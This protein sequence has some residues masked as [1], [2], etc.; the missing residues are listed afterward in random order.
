MFPWRPGRIGMKDD[1]HDGERSE[2]AQHRTLPQFLIVLD[3][4][5]RHYLHQIMV[6]IIQKFSILHSFYDHVIKKFSITVQQLNPL[7]SYSYLRFSNATGFYTSRERCTQD[8]VVQKTSGLTLRVIWTRTHILMLKRWPWIWP[9][10]PVGRELW[11]NGKWKDFSLEIKWKIQA[12]RRLERR[13]HEEERRGEI[14]PGHCKLKIWSDCEYFE[15]LNRHKVSVRASGAQSDKV[16]S[17]VPESAC[18]RLP[19][20]TENPLL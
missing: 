4:P 19:P 1:R 8:V 13:A 12:V 7:D 6:L 16:L 17:T 11:I 5:A 10:L 3:L 15:E 14:C 20:R 2:A 9:M 18:T